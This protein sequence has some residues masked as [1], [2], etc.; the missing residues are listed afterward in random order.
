MGGMDSAPGEIRVVNLAD[1]LSRVSE[2]WRPRIVG[3]LNDSHIKIAKLSGEFMWHHHDTEDE[4]FLVVSGVLTIRLRDRDLVIHPGE[5]V[6]IPHGVEHLP[7][8]PQPVEIVLLE[9]KSTLNTGT[10]ENER[11]V[12]AEWI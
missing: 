4:M 12:Q 11:T 1:K 9:P 2:Y 7:V 8:A 5:F 6:V 3:E 10:V